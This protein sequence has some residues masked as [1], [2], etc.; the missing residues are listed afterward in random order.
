MDFNGRIAAPPHNDFLAAL[1]A[2]LSDD[3][4]IRRVMSKGL[5]IAGAKK[6]L[7]RFGGFFSLDAQRRHRA[8]ARRSK[9]NNLRHFFIHPVAT[10]VFKTGI[11][12]HF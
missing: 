7:D 12:P 10:S 4:S 11:L 1:I 2:K 8:A 6:R 3:N 5:S 9:P